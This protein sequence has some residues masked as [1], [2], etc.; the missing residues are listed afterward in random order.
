MIQLAFLTKWIG[1]RSGIVPPPRWLHVAAPVLRVEF[2]LVLGLV[3]FG[4]GL[5]W[6]LQLVLDWGGTGYGP[7]DPPAIMRSAIPA[8]TMMITGVQAAAAALFAGAL[9]FSFRSMNGRQAHG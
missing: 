3:L 4:L 5:L 7:L 8:V 6:S 1:V 2:G 9:E